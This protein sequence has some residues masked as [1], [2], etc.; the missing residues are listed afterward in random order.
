MK[1]ET[2][3]SVPFDPGFSK[4]FPPIDE[5]VYAHL[6][7]I[8]K[9]KAMNQRKFQL[10]KIEPQLTAS[11]TQIICIY[12]GCVLYGSTIA[13]K[14][15]DPAATI[16]GNPM[17][18]VKKEEA[19]QIDLTLEASFFSE[20]YKLFNRSIEFNFKRKSRVTSEFLNII[21][22]YNE[23]MKKN[24]HFIN[25]TSTDQLIIP[26]SF[27]KFKDYEAEKLNEIEGIIFEAVKTGKLEKLLNIS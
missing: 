9:L 21:D 11:L 12:Y 1:K 19:N 25:V 13:S 7:G 8:C 3:Q 16:S 6:E 22:V 18:E 23:F 14:Y 2:M 15:R 5:Q 27:S 26:E 4:F 24:N 17:A 10:Q 20:L